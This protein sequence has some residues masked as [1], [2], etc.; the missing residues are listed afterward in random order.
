MV[1][2]RP[3]L[4]RILAGALLG[5]GL[6][7]GVAVAQPAGDTRIAYV[8]MKRLLDGTPSM[9]ATRAALAREFAPRNSALEADERTLA[10]LDERLRREGD[11]MAAEERERLA[12]EAGVL[13]RAI[14]R[15]RTELREALKRRT[16]QESERAW[17]RVNDAIARFAR[18]N[19]YDLVVTS[20]SVVYA[21]GRVDVT[22]RVLDLLRAES[23][24]GATP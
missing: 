12:R 6:C 23:G 5:A 24:N 4:L 10:T 7:M 11:F 22:D 17:T 2:A 8:D 3:R 9:A 14:E 20:P 15:T 21:S 16:D 1:R 13:R 18:D 19:G